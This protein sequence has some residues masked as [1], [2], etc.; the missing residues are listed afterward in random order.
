[1]FTDDRLY[2]TISKNIKKY[3]ILNNLTQAELAKMLSLDAHYYAQLERGERYFSLDKVV[4]ACNV[5]NLKLDDIVETEPAVD[6]QKE[7]YE[8]KRQNLIVDITGNLDKLSSKQLM[9]LTRY[10][11]EVLP[12]SEDK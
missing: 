9:I 6:E 12:Y 4:L 3:R 1:M 10:L 7:L 5:L 8:T 11:N 2:K